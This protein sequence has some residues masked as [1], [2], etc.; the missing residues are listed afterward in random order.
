MDGIEVLRNTKGGCE[1]IER[2][3]TWH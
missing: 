2:R 1:Q 3:D